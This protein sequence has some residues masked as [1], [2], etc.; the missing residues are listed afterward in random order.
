MGLVVCVNRDSRGQ[1]RASR[2]VIARVWGRGRRNHPAIAFALVH[3]LL[4]FNPRPRPE[5]QY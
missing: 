3:L 5:I 4:H 1:R 2:L